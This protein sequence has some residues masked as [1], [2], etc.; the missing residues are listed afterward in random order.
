[1]ASARSLLEESEALCRKLGSAWQLAYALRQEGLIAWHQ[2]NLEEAAAYAQEALALARTLGDKSLLAT[3]LLDLTAIVML[4]GDL[5]QATP[6]ASEGLALARELGDKPLLANTLQNLGY[7]AS[8]RGDLPQAAEQAQEALAL[9][10]E[11]GDRTYITVALHSWGYL[12]SLQHEF[13]QAYACYREGL[14]LA[15][16]IRNENLMGWHL[17]GLASV[18][19]AEEQ[20]V[21]AARLFGAAEKRFDVNVQMN[22][23]ERAEY[24]RVVQGVRAQLGEQTFAAAKAEGQAATFTSI[25]D[26]REPE[27][28]GEQAPK[29]SPAVATASAKTTYPA[30]LTAR[31]V[32][33][34]CAW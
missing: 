13:K 21:R 14:F 19:A 20:P 8:L 30:G 29:E 3:T 18:A 6:L 12:S 31:E 5:N 24:E 9:F 11:L 32:G 10:R 4:Q 28:S 2:G 17:T 26:A 27:P 1:M 23:I 16:E 34:F 33:I 22:E 7:I 15:Q 25:L